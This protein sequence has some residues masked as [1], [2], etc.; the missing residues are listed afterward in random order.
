MKKIPGVLVIILV[1]GF[2]LVTGSFAQRGSQKGLMWSG[3]G[4][5]GSGSAYQR[6]Y[7]PAT[8]ETITGTI[9]SIDKITP[10]KGMSY[11][12]HI[13]VKT[14]KESI[15]VH[16]GPAWY[17]EKLDTKLEKGDKVEVTGS[18]IT[19]SGKPAIIPTEVKK[20]DNVLVLRDK[21]GFPAW[22]G[23]RK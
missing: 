19:F 14:K 8:V 9:E 12:I 13:I 21:N 3:S 17:I 6:L 16:L 11:G 15:T 23:W 1:F 4:G 7:N 5:W 18:R 22:A 10:T 20:G 2:L